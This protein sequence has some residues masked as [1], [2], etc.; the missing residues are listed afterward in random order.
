MD[1][2]LLQIKLP[3]TLENMGSFIEPVTGCAE[4]QGLTPEKLI[5]LELALEEVLVNI[6]NYA[7]PKAPGDAQVTCHLD[8]GKAF[9]IEI[10]DGGIPFNI[11]SLKPP[12]VGAD[13]SERK[14][15]GLGVFLTRKLMDDVKYRRKYGKN[16]LTLKIGNQV[17]SPLLPK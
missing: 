15:G 2:L 11:L 17:G 9:V 12:D 10:E 14:I 8:G 7:Y 13:I 5:H 1:D 16:I 6:V 3:A 4:A